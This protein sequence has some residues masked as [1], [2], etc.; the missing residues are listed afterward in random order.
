M[1][2]EFFATESLATEKQALQRLFGLLLLREVRTTPRRSRFREWVKEKGGG[3]LIGGWCFALQENNG[4]MDSEVE[5]FVLRQLSGDQ[6][7]LQSAEVM[8]RLAL[9]SVLLTKS[10]LLLAVEVL[11][12]VEGYEEIITELISAGEVPTPS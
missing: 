9:R 5:S 7:E 6:P 1:G 4:Y 12:D 8:I 10:M 2:R 11:G 3:A